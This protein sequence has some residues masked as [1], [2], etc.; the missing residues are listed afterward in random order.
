MDRFLL[1]LNIGN[2]DSAAALIK[3]GEVAC[4]IE[5][6]RISRQKMAIGEPPVHAILACLRHEDITIRDISAIAVGMDWRYR[7]EIYQ[8]PESELN[9]YRMFADA[10]WFLPRSV[11]GSHLPP[12][13][14]VRHHLAHAASAYR[15]SG[16]SECAVLVVDNRGED[17]STSLGIA[18]NGNISFFKRINIHNSLG[19]FYNRAARFAGLYGK[20]REVGKFMGLASYGMPISPMPLSPSR[21][22]LLFKKLPNIENCSIHDAIRLR[23]TQ[24][25][26]YFENNCFP[27]ETGNAEEI[28]C[29]ADFA[30]SVQQALELTILDFVS[31]L[32]ERTKM[33][34]LV[35][36]GGVAL[37]CSANGKIEQSGLFR[38]IFVPPFASDSG[39]AVGSAME[40]YRQLYG[41][42]GSEVPLRHAGLG[43]SYSQTHA[44][45]ILQL[46]ADRIRWRR[47]ENA[48]LYPYVAQ[49]LA[50][51]CIVGWMQDGFEAG[52][53]A[54][55]YRS[56]LADPRTRQS[57]I[58]IN[59]I[60]QREMWRPIAPSVLFEAYSRY[61]E[62]YAESKY[63][64]NVATVVKEEK[65][66]EI[67][68]VVHVDYT[69][70]PQVVTREQRPYYELLTAFD[71]LTGVP[72][73]CNTSFN[74]QGEPLVNTVENAIE[75]FLKRNID[76]LVIGNYVVRKVQ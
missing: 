24:C 1:G 40:V 49:A 60:K 21:D 8:M 13:I 4:F 33:D 28:M 55:G 45:Q 62:G 44:K 39:T 37:N 31:E 14:S 66:K 57:L 70:R 68:A 23:T 11:F 34:H 53:R 51:G 3:N 22:G 48:E 38:H 10:N 43:L 9:K 30:A 32:K 19:V 42:F 63:F 54:L 46:Y 69:A 27:Y 74:I 56:I 29:Y 52:P 71:K 18:R 58:R 25:K 64:M 76:M 5:Q 50:S 67:A 7:N 15:I 72:V 41:K 17:S 16:F 2:H 75:C 73:L 59:K 47:Y 35:M 26:A 61:F 6:E 36:A 20:Y 65:R 12:V